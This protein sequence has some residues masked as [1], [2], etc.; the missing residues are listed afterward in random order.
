M[1]RKDDLEYLIDTV[2]ILSGPE[3]MK[4]IRKSDLDIRH[5]R[6]RVISSVEDLIKE[7]S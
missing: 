1:V 2:E 4:L 3:T 5:G 7:M 6:V